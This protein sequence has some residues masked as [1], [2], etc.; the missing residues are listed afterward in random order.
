MEIFAHGD[1]EPKTA[2]E[3]AAVALA[4]NLQSVGADFVRCWFSWRFFEPRPVPASAL[5]ELAESGYAE[6]P[7]DDFVNTLTSRGIDIVPV[8]ACGYQR[9]LPEN[10]SVDSDPTLYLRRVGVHARLLVRRYKGKIKHWQIENEPD[11]WDMH[12]AGGW[13][14]GVSWLESGAFRE[15]LLGVLE[16]AVR[17]EDP[18]ARVIV[19]LEADR[20]VTNIDLFAKHCDLIGLDFYPNYKAAE[21]INVSVFRTATEYARL[22]GKPMLIAETGY[23]SGPA[24]LGYSRLK[25]AKYVEAAMKEAFAE[26]RLRAVGIW[27]YMDTAWRSFPEQENHFGLI[28]EKSGPKDA[29][30]AFGE[31]VKTLRG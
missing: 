20:P 8:L 19:N 12:V 21:P 22:S 9:M 23:P 31:V 17:E 15:D 6:Y 7:M 10:L 26:D 4:G 2:S 11:W 16:N 14:H 25:Q 18:N 1:V 29:W 30:Y 5:D 3:R 24:L 28:D 27:R 13:R